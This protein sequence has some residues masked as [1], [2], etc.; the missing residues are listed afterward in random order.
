VNL[1][2]SVDNRWWVETNVKRPK[3]AA[4]QAS[5]PT[6]P[7]GARFYI[8]AS[9]YN[10]E[11]AK[12]HLTDNNLRLARQADPPLGDWAYMAMTEE[13]CPEHVLERLKREFTL[14]KQARGIIIDHGR[15][16]RLLICGPQLEDWMI[17]VRLA[18]EAS[19]DVYVWGT[20]YRERVFR[21]TRDA[22]KQAQ[23]WALSLINYPPPRHDVVRGDLL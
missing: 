10:Q 3:S 13:R 4:S 21:R 23:Q 14:P 19:V 1:K 11:D 18:S 6:L 5:S 12:E 9:G 8:V 20:L 16:V 7:V 2:S 17:D 15:L 22:I